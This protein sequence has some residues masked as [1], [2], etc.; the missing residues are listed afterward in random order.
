MA[1]QAEG[2]VKEQQAVE[3][4]NGL[5]PAAESEALCTSALPPLLSLFGLCLGLEHPGGEDSS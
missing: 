5:E 1:L 2:A 4:T 3:T